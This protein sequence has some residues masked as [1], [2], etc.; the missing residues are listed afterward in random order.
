VIK[1]ATGSFTSADIV[2]GGAG[3][4]TIAIT[5]D[6][7]TVVDADFT[8]VTNVEQLTTVAGTT[9]QMTSFTLG[10][11]AMAAGIN[12]VLM[13]DTSAVDTVV[14]GAGITSAITVDLDAD[15]AANVVSAAAY[16]GVL[17]ITA[18]DDDLDSNASTLTG[19][20]GTSDELKITTTSNLDVVL[21]S[22]M[23][24]IEKVTLVGA[25]GGISLTTSNASIAS[26][27]NLAIDLTA[28]DDDANT[29]D[30][31]AESN[32][33]VTITADG[34][35]AH[36]ITLGAG[37]DSYTHTGTTGVSTVVGTKGNNIITTGGGADIVTLGTGTDTVTSGGGNDTI[38]A[39][40]PSVAAGVTTA[41]NFTS[42]DI[43]NAGAGTDTLEILTDG[44]T[45]V[46]TDLLG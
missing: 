42:A 13:A 4:D 30:A 22:G 43:I 25:T 38:K 26:G 14:I 8:N 39:T 32:G 5:T 18:A 15:G 16:T 20:T 10:A 1:F 44:F 12:K 19:G 35:G 40:G 33:T 31:S 28:S 3:T 24:A 23:T 46:D 11:L 45:L 37:N 17:T 21:T 41:R 34:T 29:V 9:A 36:I 7:S 2:D 27:A 6:G